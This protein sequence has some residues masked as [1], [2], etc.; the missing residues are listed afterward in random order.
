MMLLLP[1]F[2]L[3]FG[4]VMVSVSCW[5]YNAMA[6]FTGGIEFESRSSEG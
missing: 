6:R 1:L 3:G 5:L 2:Y 4:Y